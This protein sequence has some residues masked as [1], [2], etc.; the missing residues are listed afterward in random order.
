MFL[1]N[2]GSLSGDQPKDRLTMRN[3]RFKESVRTE[4]T[5]F[6]IYLMLQRGLMTVAK[7][8]IKIAKEPINADNSSKK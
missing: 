2:E 1:F 8:K 5:K 7:I 3:N 6:Y 4:R